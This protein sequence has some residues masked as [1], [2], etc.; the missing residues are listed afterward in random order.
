[1]VQ[2]VLHVAEGNRRTLR[3]RSRGCERG[4]AQLYVRD[5]TVDK[6][7]GFRP[8]RVDAL[9]QQQQFARAGEPGQSRQQPG[10]AVIAG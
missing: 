8:L 1:V 5:D 2:I 10:D 9:G 3:Q 7:Q 6:T 4:L